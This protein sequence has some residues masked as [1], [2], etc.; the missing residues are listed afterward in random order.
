MYH[1]LLV[2]I[3]STKEILLYSKYIRRCKLKNFWKKNKDLLYLVWGQI[4]SEQNKQKQ[5]EA[6][7][8]KSDWQKPMWK[9]TETDG[10]MDSII[11]ITAGAEARR[12]SHTF[13]WHTGCHLFIPTLQLI[14]CSLPWIHKFRECFAACLRI[15]AST[16][17]V[18]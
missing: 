5:M 2:K 8:R 9:S 13:T 11:C 15:S 16:L 7:R 6:I 10:K 18:F 3:K 4:F 1:F 12:T 17:P 14:P